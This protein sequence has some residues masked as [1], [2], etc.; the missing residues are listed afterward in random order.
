[1]KKSTQQNTTS[2]H[3]KNPQQ[4]EGTYLNMIKAMYDNS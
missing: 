2:F 1:M 3:E 4:I